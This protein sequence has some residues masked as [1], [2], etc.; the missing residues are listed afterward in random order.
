MRIFGVLEQDSLIT[1]YSVFHFLFGFFM[2]I[3]KV[4]P[5]TVTVLHVG[6]ELFENSSAGIQFF[7]QF[8][9]RGY[10]GDHV[11]NSVA[12]VLF[13]IVGYYVGGKC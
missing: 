13:G 5:Y 7:R 10:G 9:F 11:L 2:A 3:S 8:G 4:D 12:D 1:I 6:F